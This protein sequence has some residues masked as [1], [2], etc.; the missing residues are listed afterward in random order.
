MN[1]ISATGRRPWVAMPID[2][3][4]I[5]PSARG[6]SC[7]R[8]LPNC[9]CKPA[10]ARNTP[11]LTPTSSP[12]TTTDGSR[13]ISHA[14]A[15][16]MASIIVTL[17]MDWV[18][19]CVLAL[20][21]DALGRVLE[22]VVEHRV[23]VRPRSTRIGINSGFDLARAFRL[24]RLLLRVA[25]GTQ[26]GQIGACA[27]QRLLLPRGVQLVRAA[28]AAGIIRGR[29]IAESIR[30]G[31]DQRRAAACACFGQRFI[32]D[33]PDGNEIVAVDLYAWNPRGDG[34]L[35]QRPGRGLPFDRHRDGPSVVDDHENGWQSGS[36][37]EIDGLVERTFRG[38]AVTDVRDRAARLIAYLHRHGGARGVQQLRADRHRPGKILPRAAE[39]AACLVSAPIDQ[40]LRHPHTAPELC[41]VLAVVGSEH[42]LR[43]HG[44][45]DGDVSGLV[46]QAR[47]IRAE[48]AGALQIDGLGVE[49]AH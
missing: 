11:P 34:F 25:P 16:L 19:P 47:R 5:M 20:L 40:N 31:L 41:A 8:S 26:P 32:H 27:Q 36:A 6:V 37:C 39:A 24:Q 45:P 4:A 10:V 1:W 38:P 46:T 29:V 30:Q 42:V 35:R 9:S 21:A 23:S 13:V 3:P 7:T 43:A 33:V 18:A 14:C 44:G 2:I 28:I 15:R 17:A 12:S 49:G 22:E 48:L